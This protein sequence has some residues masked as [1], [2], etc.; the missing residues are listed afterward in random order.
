MNNDIISGFDDERVDSLKI[1]LE[2]VNE[3][4]LILSLDGYIDT[5][6]SLFF[7]SRVSKAIV[8]GF[9]QLIFNCEKLTYISSTGI[10]SFSVFLKTIKPRGGDAVLVNVAPKIYEVFHLLGFSHFFPIKNSV[11]EA[12]DFLTST[13]DTGITDCFPTLL[14]CPICRHKMNIKRPG[15]YRCSDCKTILAVDSNANVF[16][17]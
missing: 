4:C 8:V 10:G 11:A 2:K 15:R 7:Q 5:Y 17:G 9:L 14:H 12:I 13:S 16:L 1:V 6:N 3:Q